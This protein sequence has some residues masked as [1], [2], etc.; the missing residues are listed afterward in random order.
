[1][2]STNI[3]NTSWP[4]ASSSSTSFV[5]TP[6][7][8]ACASSSRCSTSHQ[9]TVSHHLKVSPPTGIVGSEREGL[10]A[11][12]YVIPEALGELSA[13]LSYTDRHHRDMLASRPQAVCCARTRRAASTGAHEPDTARSSPSP[14]AAARGSAYLQPADATGV[15]GGSLYDEAGRER[16]TR[17]RGQRVARLRGTHRGRRTC[18]RARPCSIFG[19]GAGA[20]VL[21]SARRVG[22][23]GK[24]IG[25]DMTDEML[26]LARANAHDAGVE[27]VEFIKGYLEDIPVGDETV[28]VVISNCVINLSGDKPSVIRGDRAGVA[29]RWTVCR[30]RRD[31]RSGHATSTRAPTWPR[32]LGASRARL[33]RRSSEPRC[34]TP[35]SRTSR[36]A[37]T[38][39]VHEHAVAAIVR[40]R[41]PALQ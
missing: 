26:A 25:L 11:Y 40:A 14:A 15:F 38:H 22:P 19:S 13:W 34:R 35:G 10:W 33:R 6:A 18:T 20:D 27:N 41:K 7:R 29:S 32:G 2:P 36:F 9:P 39:R 24:A 31:Y 5:S 1:M 21:I 16:R 8:C 17:V 28:D 3:A 12:Y 37:E 23:T 4:S 30:L